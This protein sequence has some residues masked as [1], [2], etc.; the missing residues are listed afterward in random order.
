MKNRGIHLTDLVFIDENPD[1][2]NYKGN[3]LINF[4]KRKS[5]YYII[6]QVL[7]L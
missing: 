4:K 2:I 3:Q 6:S 5:I 1:Y 7:F